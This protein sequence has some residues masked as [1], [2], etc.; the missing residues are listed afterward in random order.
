[1]ILEVK[2]FLSAQRGRY[3]KH[4]RDNQIEPL[5]TYFS[6]SPTIISNNC[7][8]GFFYQDLN[9]PYLSPTAGL[10]FFF[11]DYIHFLKDL[12]GNLQA[13]LRFVKESK[14]PLGNERYRKAKMNYPI[15]L[16]NDS[17]EIHFL[18]YA[19]QH[20]AESKWYKRAERAKLDNLVVFGTQLDLCT[21]DDI[22]AFDQFDFER[23]F[24]FTRK[25]LALPSTIYIKEF[26]ND[27][28]IG[29]PYKSGHILYKKL[30]DKIYGRA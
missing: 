9:L 14:Y 24:F 17:F 7:L 6:D 19:T 8:A 10:Y 1:M 28:K 3:F 22:R 16:L 18:H 23:K 20:E 26:E 21:E 13:R 2:K 4:L 25:E 11:P 12:K 15:A 30:A 27:I 29:D 5:K